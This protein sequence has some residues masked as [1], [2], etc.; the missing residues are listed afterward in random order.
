[1]DWTDFRQRSRKEAENL[2]LDGWRSVDK[3]EL[4]EHYHVDEEH[5]ELL[6]KI[7]RDPEGSKR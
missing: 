7:L 3:V 1:M 4:M 2:F 5:A 6:C